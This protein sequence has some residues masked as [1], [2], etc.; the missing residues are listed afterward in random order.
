V[1]RQLLVVRARGDDRVAAQLHD[2]AGLTH[3]ARATAPLI[4]PES[5][6]AIVAEPSGVATLEIV[7][8]GNG[9]QPNGLLRVRDVDHDGV[10][11]AR[12]GEQVHRRV[13][14]HVV[15]VARAGVQRPRGNR[16]RRVARSGA[17]STASTATASAATTSRT[18]R[19]CRSA[20]G[21]AIR[22][23]FQAGED[24]C[25]RDHGGLLGVI[26]RHLDDV[27]LVE[28]VRWVGRVIAVFA[29]GKLCLRPRTLLPRDIDVHD[30]RVRRA[31]DEGMRVRAFA[32]LH[33]LDQLRRFR[34]RD[35][36]DAHARHVILRVLHAA[37]A[38]VVAI[39]RAF[40]RDE[41]EVADDRGIALRRDALHDRREDGFCRIAHVPHHEAGEV[42]LVGVVA[43]AERQVGVDERQTARRVELRRLRRERHEAHVAR[44]DSR[45]EPARFEVVPRI[46]GVWIGLRRQKRRCG[47]HRNEADQLP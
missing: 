1:L 42:A 15:T 13:R 27:E 29:S 37:L 36:V 26:E 8:V 21:D 11:R 44:R 7:C 31:G 40:G 14:G 35:I 4:G 39:A 18:A 24:P 3:R 19:I 30:L 5:L 43:V 12:G 20:E 17:T 23:T 16:V 38:A 32:R 10:A 6:L 33:V 28:R 22:R 2:A 9:G 47:Q 25:A 46:L 45:V 41:E 34:V